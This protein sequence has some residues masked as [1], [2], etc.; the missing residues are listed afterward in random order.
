MQLSN[1]LATLTLAALLGGCAHPIVIT[2]DA[3]KLPTRDNIKPSANIVGYYIS[4]EERG[5]QVVTPGG[6]G[7]KVEYAPYK[8]LEPGIFRVLNN[9]FANVHVLKSEG[10]TAYLTDNR[11][12]FVVRPQIT[13]NSSSGS[14]FTWPPTDF[15]VVINIKAVD[16]AGKT[17]WQDEAV[18]QGKA[19]FS[20]FKS[21]FSLSA[22]RASEQALTQL[23]TKLLA[24]PL[25]R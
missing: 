14:P 24:S 4:E 1:R 18:G 8:E 3:A 7:D 9:V 2:P 25:M 6:G 22:K 13:T 17:V 5:R 15:T 11:I 12:A 21:D 20:E 23:Q 19:E 16:D 10:D